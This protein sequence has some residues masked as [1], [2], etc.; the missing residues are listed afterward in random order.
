MQI[1]PRG[2]LPRCVWPTPVVSIQNWQ[3]VAGDGTIF[4][5]ESNCLLT[6]IRPHRRPITSLWARAPITKAEFIAE[7]PK[8]AMFDVDVSDS[9]VEC[10]AKPGSI[11]SAKILAVMPV[12]R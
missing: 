5:K 6:D 12:R 3:F 2:T 11:E 8:V 10:Q 7:S 1:Q 9:L 4:A